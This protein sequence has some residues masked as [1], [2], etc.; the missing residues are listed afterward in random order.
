MPTAILP[1]PPAELKQLS[2]LLVQKIKQRIDLQ[3]CLPFSQF[4]EMALYEPGLGY[5]SA[6]LHKFGPDGDFITAPELG[7]LFAAALARQLDEIAECI[8]AGKFGIMEIGAG[9]GRLA[10]DLLSH[11]TRKPDRYR[12]LERSGDLRDRQRR[13]I[14][15][16]GFSATAVE[17]L[18]E[19][20]GEPWQGAIVANELLDAMPVERFRLHGGDIKQQCLRAD[21]Q[22]HFEHASEAVQAGVNHLKGTL[23]EELPDEYTSEINLNVAGL[24]DAVSSTMTHGAMLVIDYG[25]PRKE[26][27]LPQRSD[28]T[29]MCH[30]R[31][32]AH[33]D[34]L[35]YPGLQDITAFVDFTA[36]AEGA[37][38]CGLQV[39]GYTS[40]AMFLLGCGLADML[41][42]DSTADLSDP[43]REKQAALAAEAR[44]LMMPGEMGE[45]FQVMALT[46]GLDD[47]MLC[48]FSGNDLRYRL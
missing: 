32:R 44:R 43:D 2:A 20:P 45:R 30:Y 26:Y 12:I 22:W 28:G 10:A 42:V 37:D 41:A 11:L 5:Y 36:V 46:R 38:Q 48:G 21:G 24:L 47:E 18:D 14:E 1:E 17:W 4:M 8:P 19:P 27:Y 35:F 16:A 33:E 25:Y 29:L 7:S 31:H 6:G 39:S 13:T 34:A 23:T 15:S 40:Q 9:T 3:G